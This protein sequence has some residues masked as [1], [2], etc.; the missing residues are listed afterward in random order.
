MSVL[1]QFFHLIGSDRYLTASAVELAVGPHPLMAS[2]WEVYRQHFQEF[3]G[4]TLDPLFHRLA[5][6]SVRFGS[7]RLDPGTAVVV[8]GTGP[9]LRPN[10]AGLK[11]LKGR[12]RIFTSPRGAEALLPHGI[13]PDLV[14]VEHQ[15]ALDAHHSARHLTDSTQEIL[16]ACPL[17]AADWRTPASLL[18][19]IASDQLFVPAPLPTWGVWIATVAAMAIEAGASRVSLVGVDLGTADA[20]DPAHA[21]LAAILSLLARLS[22]IVALDC[23]AGGAT[24]RGWLKGSIDEAGGATV[25]GAC[26]LTA[27]RSPSLSARADEAR[28]ALEKLSPVVDRARALLALASEVRDG[29]PAGVSAL[30]DAAA[31]IM[32]WRETA[33]IR[34][35]AQ[36][37]L[38]LAFL[39]RL[40]RAG[41]DVSLGQA[42][43]RPLMLA[44][45]EMI[46]QADALA[47]A[48]RI[49]KAA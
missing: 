29:Q 39:P 33:D 34:M 47:S 23:G 8:V 26:E 16:T 17:I 20:P 25:N 46:R 35:F 9:S 43:W 1:P 14:F 6:P 41:I 3:T 36:E 28:D 49:A 38:G 45:H 30:P 31:E 13:V 11:R 48:T 15:T 22:P 12:V 4:S 21:P 19:G 40:W 18:A 7:L 32:A 24:K 44:T 42:L 10:I 37:C 2:A 5:H 27:H